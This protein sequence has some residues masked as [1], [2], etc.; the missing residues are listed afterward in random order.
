MP[1][2]GCSTNEVLA[3]SRGARRTGLRQRRASRIRLEGGGG[4]G[5]RE[6]RKALSAYKDGAYNAM[7]K[8]LVAES[9]GKKWKDLAAVV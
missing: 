4:A 3:R 5:Q 8:E 6:E 9:Q 1:P 2:K 7:N